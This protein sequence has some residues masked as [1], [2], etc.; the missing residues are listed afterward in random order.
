[1]MVLHSDYQPVACRSRHVY[2]I[3]EPACSGVARGEQ[4]GDV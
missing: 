3:K 2:V 1:M 4:N